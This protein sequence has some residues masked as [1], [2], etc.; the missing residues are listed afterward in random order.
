[1]KLGSLIVSYISREIIAC[2]KLVNAVTRRSEYAE[3]EK[4]EK[5]I[6]PALLTTFL[7]LCVH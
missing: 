1:M 7:N 6:I 2:A 4:Y 3:W 5:R